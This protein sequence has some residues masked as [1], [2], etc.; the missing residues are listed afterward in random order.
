MLL[1]H[2]YWTCHLSVKTPHLLI[3]A[4]PS[5]TLVQTTSSDHDTLLV[6]SAYDFY[7]KYIRVTWHWNG[8][9]VTSGMTIS[10]V[11]TNGDWTYQVHSYL[12]YTASG[13][14]R[15]MTGVRIEGQCYS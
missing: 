1:P 4:G 12:E 11:M 5:V 2:R 10:E 15:F 3:S 9:E 13:S 8:Q 7:P 6:C 14:P